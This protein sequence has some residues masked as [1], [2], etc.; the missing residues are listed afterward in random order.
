[1]G[2]QDANAVRASVEFALV[3]SQSSSNSP[4][5]ALGQRFLEAC[6]LDRAREADLSTSCNVGGFR[7][8]PVEIR[9]VRA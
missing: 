2:W 3:G 9:I 8:M 7:R 6:R 5:V 4:R 1:M